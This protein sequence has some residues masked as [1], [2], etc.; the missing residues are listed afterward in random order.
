ME[1]GGVRE[2]VWAGGRGRAAAGT[3]GVVLLGGAKKEK[4]GSYMLLFLHARVGAPRHLSRTHQSSPPSQFSRP[5]Q[6][7]APHAHGMASDS[8][9]AAK[10]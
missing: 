9:S 7:G 5:R 10:R 8:P 4:G 1:T 6:E 2:G 3:C